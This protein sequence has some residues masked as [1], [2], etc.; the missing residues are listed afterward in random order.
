MTRF[1]G[2]RG[3]VHEGHAHTR[4]KPHLRRLIGVAVAAVDA[5]AIHP[6]VVGRALWTNDGSG[7]FLKTK[8]KQKVIADEFRAIASKKPR[9]VS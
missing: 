9:S 3:V 6:V 8:T 1:H 7:P 2:A 4:P 5:Q